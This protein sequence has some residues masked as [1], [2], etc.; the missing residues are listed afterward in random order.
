MAKIA[1]IGVAKTNVHQVK[2]DGLTPFKILLLRI[3]ET[4]E[5]NDVANA[6]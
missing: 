3:I 4:A 2:T 5:M 6:K 1:I